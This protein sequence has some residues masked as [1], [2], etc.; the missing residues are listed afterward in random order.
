M[1]SWRAV[2][3]QQIRRVKPNGAWRLT[4]DQALDFHHLPRGWKCSLQK[5]ANASFT[6]SQCSRQWSSHR[7]VILFHLHYKPYTRQG[8]VQM[9]FFRQRCIVCHSNK[10][11][12]PEFTEEAVTKVVKQLIRSIR[13]KCYGEPIDDTELDQ[14]DTNRTGPHRHEYCEAYNLGINRSG[15]HHATA[16]D[17]RDEEPETPVP[18]FIR[19]DEPTRALVCAIC[20]ICFIFLFAIIFP[21][22]RKK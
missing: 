4:M 13:K 12:G 18:S 20:V 3:E 11:E 14:V 21:A 2:F 16:P 10:Y 7:V 5:H 19:L 8:R 15:G 6:C 1:N 17:W 22:D 9:R